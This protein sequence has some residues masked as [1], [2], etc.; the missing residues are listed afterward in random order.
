LGRQGF[1]LFTKRLEHGAFLWPPSVKPDETL[2]LTSARLSLLIEGVDWRAGARLATGDGGLPWN[3]RANDH[4]QLNHV[5]E[6]DAYTFALPTATVTAGNWS[7]LNFS[8]AD[9]RRPARP[10]GLLLGASGWSVAVKLAN[11][12]HRQLERLQFERR[13]ILTTLCSCCHRSSSK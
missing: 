12:D 11:G 2:L 10:D 5:Q 13:R 6:M 4:P 9:G 3:W 8:A 1:C 7:G